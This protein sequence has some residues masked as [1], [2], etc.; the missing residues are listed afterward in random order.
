[1]GMRIISEL[2]SFFV[3]LDL[4]QRR[5][6]SALAVVERAEVVFDERDRVTYERRRALRYR[7]RFLERVRLG[8]PY[9]DVVGRVREVL[10]RPALAG[11]CML[12]MD[13][14]GVGQPV[15]D[16]LRRANLGC[17]IAPVIITGGE[18][19]SHAGGLWHVPKRDLITGLR[20]MLEK[21]ELSF[22]GK[23]PATRLLTRELADFE[24]R[25]TRRGGVTFGAWREGQHDDLVIAAALACWRARWKSG[26]IW[27][28]RSLGLW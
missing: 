22:P 18:R 10:R 14:T 19:E 3:G 11:R 15:L 5:D 4:G 8:T 16:L 27:G 1:M 2:I 7:V 12:A 13:A 9:P 25:T 17:L 20:V 24:E 26:G 6:P 21:E 28:T 23:L